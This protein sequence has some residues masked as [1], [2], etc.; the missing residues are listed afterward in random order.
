M[1]VPNSGLCA[2]PH[3]ETTVSDC[4]HYT[5]VKRR[6]WNCLYERRSVSALYNLHILRSYSDN[7]RTVHLVY[8]IEVLARLHKIALRPASK[9]MNQPPGIG[10]RGPGLGTVRAPGRCNDGPTGSSHRLVMVEEF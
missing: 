8:T 2:V 4:V 10:S 9:A 6:E 5:S 7:A 1:N 3:A